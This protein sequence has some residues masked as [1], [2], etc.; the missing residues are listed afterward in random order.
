MERVLIGKAPLHPFVLL[1]LLRQSV[2]MLAV[3]R[4][5]RPDRPCPLDSLQP[6]DRQLLKAPEPSPALQCGRTVQ[7]I[8]S[9]TEGDHREC[10]AKLCTVVHQ[11]GSLDQSPRAVI[12]LLLSYAVSEDGALHFEKYYR[13]VTEEFRATRPAF[14]WR[15]LVTL[16]RVTASEYGPPAAGLAEARERLGIE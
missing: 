9:Q 16:A 11:I 4:G 1:P 14:R 6:S 3:L 12:D 7:E 10:Q 5:N 15:H 8:F 2:S 13:T